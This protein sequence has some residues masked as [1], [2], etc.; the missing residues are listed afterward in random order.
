MK[1]NIGCGFDKMAGYHNVDM[2][3]ECEPDEVVDLSKYPWPWADASADEIV[4]KHVIEHIPGDFWPFM[5]ECARVLKPGGS[6][7]I[8]CPD[9]SSSTALTYRDHHRVFGPNS[10]HGCDGMRHGTSAWA[11]KHMNSL[12]LKLMLYRKVPHKEFYWMMRWPFRRLLAFCARHMRNFIHEQ[13][14]VFH[15]LPDREAKR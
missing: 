3:A 15:R 14:F 10:F 8:S 7:S 13:I 9:E 11:A 12:P 5:Q 6:L 1:L 2:C 4:A